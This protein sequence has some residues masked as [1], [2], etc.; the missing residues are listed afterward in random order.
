MAALRQKVKESRA[1]Q[2]QAVQSARELVEA[3]GARGQEADRALTA[4][5]KAHAALAERARA[6]EQQVRAP[7]SCHAH[8]LTTACL[9]RGSV[10]PVMG[11]SSLVCTGRD[12]R[13]HTSWCLPAAGWREEGPDDAAGVCEGADRA[14]DTASKGG[15]L[16]V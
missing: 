5:R 1:A 10:W 13:W 8:A 2:Q 7:V 9:R 6:L 14:V 12:G 16:L 4:E 11:G 3:A 15:W